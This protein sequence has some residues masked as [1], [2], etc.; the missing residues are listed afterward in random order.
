MRSECISDGLFCCSRA[1]VPRQ[2]PEEE[3]K[4][5]L[6]ALLSREYRRTGLGKGTLR[7]VRLRLRLNCRLGEK[8]PKGLKIASVYTLSAHLEMLMRL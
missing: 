3:Q 2:V 6:L 5:E 7:Q 4:A 8:M 1:V